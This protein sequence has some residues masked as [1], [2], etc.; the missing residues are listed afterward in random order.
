MNC[1]QNCNK[2]KKFSKLSLI[3]IFFW[4]WA[5]Q[6]LSVGMKKLGSVWVMETNNFFFY[7]KLLANIFSAIGVNFDK[8]FCY[9]PQIQHKHD[10]FS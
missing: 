7:A 9:L 10:N 1:Q 6:N 3:S 5:E 8:N 2:L 4:N